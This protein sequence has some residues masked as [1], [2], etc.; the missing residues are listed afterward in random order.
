MD[1]RRNP[2]N[3]DPRRNFFDDNSKQMEQDSRKH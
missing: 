1:R 2:L 3:E